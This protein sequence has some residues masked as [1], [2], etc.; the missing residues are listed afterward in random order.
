MNKAKLRC[1]FLWIQRK[2][3]KVIKCPIFNFILA[4]VVICSCLWEV[5]PTL[6]EDLKSFNLGGH[7]GASLLGI[8]HVLRTF[9]ELREP[10]EWISD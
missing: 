6:L 5:C 10:V 4:G 8:W 9:A 1:L 7:H 2:I 3:R